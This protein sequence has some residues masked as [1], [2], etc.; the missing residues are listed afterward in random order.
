M[1][2]TSKPARHMAKLRPKTR[3]AVETKNPQAAAPADQNRDKKVRITLE[4]DQQ[5]LRLLR[6][7][8]EMNSA[9]RGWLLGTDEASHI[10]PSQVLGLLV[11]MEARGGTVEQISIST[12]FMWRSNIDVIHDERR[13]YQAN[14]GHPHVLISGPRLHPNEKQ[15]CAK[16]QVVFETATCSMCAT[17]MPA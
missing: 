4:L 16:H 11:Y 2:F 8:I 1:K 7:N 17:G 5:F 3:P 14:A 9:T 15:W 10:T 6:A 13:V 12:P